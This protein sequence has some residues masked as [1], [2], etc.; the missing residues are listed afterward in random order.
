MW[1]ST[2]KNVSTE[3]L[4]STDKGMRRPGLNN[5]NEKGRSVPPSFPGHSCRPLW[6]KMRYELLRSLNNMLK[7]NQ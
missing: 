4:V 7:C 3:Q 1:P 5:S 6:I 2:A